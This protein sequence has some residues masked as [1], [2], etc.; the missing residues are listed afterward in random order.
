MN[1][2]DNMFNIME[3]CLKKNI[4]N[5]GCLIECIF[6]LYI[7]KFNNIILKNSNI[8]GFFIRQQYKD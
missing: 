2:Y 4:G 5:E 6:Y 8:H 3:Y 1:F 7:T